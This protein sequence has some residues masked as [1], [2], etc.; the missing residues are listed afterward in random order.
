MLTPPHPVGRE[1]VRDLLF[2]KLAPARS[3]K[4]LSRALSLARAALA[5][6]GQVTAPLLQADRANVWLG[7]DVLL[8]IDAEAHEDGLRSAGRCTCPRPLGVMTPGPRWPGGLASGS[9]EEPVS[10][11][12]RRRRA[13]RSSAAP[14]S[15]T[16]P[17]LTGPASK[18][19][20][21]CTRATGAVATP[22]KPY[23]ERSNMP[24]RS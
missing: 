8:D 13:A 20:G 12:W 24:S 15:T 5:R 3:A 14:A 19:D 16:R 21:L 18:W 22:P 4:A 23:G 11:H 7:E 9:C 2:P 1:V 17:G 10:G 6:L